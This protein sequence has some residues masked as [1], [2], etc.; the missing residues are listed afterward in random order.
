MGKV[1]KR[2]SNDSTHRFRKPADGTET[3]HLWVANAGDDYKAVM[4]YFSHWGQCQVNPHSKTFVYVS[5]LG[6]LAPD[7]PPP[8]LLNNIGGPGAIESAKRALEGASFAG[9]VPELQNRRLKVAPAECVPPEPEKKILEGLRDIKDT[10]SVVIPGLELIYD[11]IGEKEASDLLRAIDDM[12]Y[13]ENIKRRVQHYGYE[14]DYATR[15]IDTKKP[16]G[17]MPPWALTLI[18]RLVSAGH[19]KQIPDQI[20]VNEYPGGIGISSHVDTHSAFDE[21]LVSLTL[22]ASTVMDMKHPDGIQYKALYLLPR[23]LLVLRGESRYLWSHGIVARKLDRVHGKIV[24][25]PRTLTLTL[26]LTLIGSLKDPDESVLPSDE[27]ARALAAAR[28]LQSATRS[29][30][31]I[32]GSPEQPESC[33]VDWHCCVTVRSGLT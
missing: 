23:S 4:E 21:E 20:T 11:V 25:R 10:E 26:T 16:L 24:E 2:Q 22:G 1:K 14:F 28:G 31:M 5:Y 33:S 9:E 27:F 6:D 30:G 19:I 3:R 32:P 13:L 15:H 29:S 12:P 17:D 8:H 7:E 18:D